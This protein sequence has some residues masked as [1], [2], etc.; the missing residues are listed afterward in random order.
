MYYQYPQNYYTTNIICNIVD[1][2]INV[3]LPIGDN[4]GKYYND[5]KYIVNKFEL[6]LN[7]FASNWFDVTESSNIDFILENTEWGDVNNDGKILY[8]GI[9]YDFNKIYNKIIDNIK[10]DKFAVLFNIE[11]NELFDND[12]IKNYVFVDNILTYTGSDMGG[13]VKSNLL[14]SS[15]YNLSQLVE[16]KIAENEKYNYKYETEQ[17]F[18]YNSKGTGKYVNLEDLKTLPMFSNLSTFDNIYYSSN[19]YFLR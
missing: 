6:V 17:Y 3:L 13:N 19:T 5:Y 1:N 8:K 2:S 10:I 14:L 12:T 7:N 15:Y 16:N 4:I 18:T 9:L 11:D